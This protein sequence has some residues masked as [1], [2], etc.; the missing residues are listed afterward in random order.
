MSAL[1]ICLICVGLLLIIVSFFI[2]E[3]LSKKEINELSRLS[4]AQ[5]QKVVEKELESVN[6]RVEEAI[7]QAMDEA[8]ED[9]RRPMEQLT[10]EKIMAINEYSDTVIDSINKSHNEVVFLYN[11][12]NDK[13]EDIKD[14]VANIDRNK[15]RLREMTDE[16]RVLVEKPLE[17]AT[18]DSFEEEE[19]G[20]FP[21]KEDVKAIANESVEE[22]PEE[23]DIIP[24]A[25]SFREEAPKEE[26][27]TDV[28]AQIL[29]MYEE[30]VSMVD[31]GKQLGKGIG[32]V[33]LVIDLAN[34]GGQN[35]A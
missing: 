20:F 5:L 35:E 4:S 6:E 18:M 26:A 22:E 17:A 19:S 8:L 7:G 13:Q 23:D 34:H 24:S 15:A 25:F 3:K 16:A 12:L 10:N 29:K 21:I 28:R 30:G 27:V 9:S 14:L 1:Q 2:T 11:M 33:K 31:I 32:E